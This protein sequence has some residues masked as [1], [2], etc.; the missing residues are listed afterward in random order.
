MSSKRKK[1]L[2]CYYLPVIIALIRFIVTFVYFMWNPLNLSLRYLQ[3]IVLLIYVAH[4]FMYLKLFDDGVPVIS[5]I[6]P[7]L[8]HWIII[9]V[10]MKEIQLLQIGILFAIDIIFL[11]TKGLKAS[12]FPFDID[13]DDEEDL[14][15]DI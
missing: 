7:D 9:F 11:C 14:F 4:I 8:V 5:I 6:A 2:F 10:F 15:D 3:V 1:M 13:G 12:Y